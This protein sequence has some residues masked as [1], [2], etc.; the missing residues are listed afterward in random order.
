MLQESFSETIF[1][2]SA[3]KLEFKDPLRTRFPQRSIRLD[4][5][6]R[7]RPDKDNPTRV[8]HEHVKRYLGI[9]PAVAGYV[10]IVLYYRQRVNYIKDISPEEMVLL[11]KAADICPT[12]VYQVLRKVNFKKMYL[13]DVYSNNAFAYSIDDFV[14][15]LQRRLWQVISSTHILGAPYLTFND[16]L[17]RN[18]NLDTK[19]EAR[20]R[21]RDIDHETETDKDCDFRQRLPDSKDNK[22]KICTSEWKDQ[23]N[24]E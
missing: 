1:Q 24:E 21:I 22:S 7:N 5:Q 3:M 14:D 2:T 11:A 8:L 17:D 15:I 4:I 13:S 10:E 12:L 18:E 20:L 19:N 23:Q 16:F 9:G 6:Q